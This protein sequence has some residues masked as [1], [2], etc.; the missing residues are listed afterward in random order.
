MFR[1]SD[2][3]IRRTDD[4]DFRIDID[5]RHRC[6]SRGRHEQGKSIIIYFIVYVVCEGVEMFGTNWKFIFS[7]SARIHRNHTVQARHE[8]TRCL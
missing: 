1:E 7:W 8:R 2:S 6:Q 3:A 5:T 4:N